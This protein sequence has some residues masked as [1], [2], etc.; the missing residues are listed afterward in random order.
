VNGCQ[1][2]NTQGITKPAGTAKD[3]RYAIC[4]DCGAAL[5]SFRKDDSWG[6]GEEGDWVPWR[7]EVTGAE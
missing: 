1:H 5:Y 7:E 6:E 3:W 4:L 2:D